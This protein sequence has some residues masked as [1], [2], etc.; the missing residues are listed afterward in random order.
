ID[1]DEY[2][3]GGVVP[4]DRPAISEE[5]LAS[6]R[7]T[8]VA[9]KTKLLPRAGEEKKAKLNYNVAL[10]RALK[11][12]AMVRPL[13]NLPG[14]PARFSGVDLVVIREITEDLYSAI[15]HEIV[16]G[17]VESIKVVTRT[18]SERFFRFAYE[19]A[20]QAKRKSIT[21]VHKANILKKADGLILETF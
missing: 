16:A 20:R 2:L 15:E 13:K 10:R 12:Y 18:A 19:Y 11:L 21:C 14:L 4:K 6:V 8:G 7:S 17:V 3:A 1:W 5:L 9:L